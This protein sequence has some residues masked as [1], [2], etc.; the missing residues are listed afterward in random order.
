MC[1]GKVTL[2]AANTRALGR[3]PAWEQG[4]CC[5]LLTQGFTPSMEKKWVAKKKKKMRREVLP[6][7]T[8]VLWIN[9]HTPWVWRKCSQVLGS[10]SLQSWAGAGRAAASSRRG[11]G[12]QRQ[13]V[14]KAGCIF[15][16]VLTP[17]GLLPL[18]A[19]GLGCACQEQLPGLGISPE[20]RLRGPTGSWGACAG[21]E[22]RASG[23][24]TAKGTK[25]N[26]QKAA[27]Q[28]AGLHPLAPRGRTAVAQAG[29][30]TAG[31]IPEVTAAR[32]SLFTL[33][34]KSG[35][36]ESLSLQRVR[37][38]P[39]PHQ[40]GKGKKPR[41]YLAAGF[42]KHSRGEDGF[43]WA[44]RSQEQQESP[45]AGFKHLKLNQAQVV[46]GREPHPRVPREADPAGS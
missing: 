23:L 43:P 6:A 17:A 5:S 3:A 21:G 7:P 44:G 46:T 19:D 40:Q 27:H 2:R 15:G 4:L 12:N 24:L 20:S 39:P 9:P 8:A 41:V 26:Q 34:G 13:E 11:A 1:G 30:V 32:L 16:C 33:Q 10:T 42:V 22:Q 45:R 29:G 28:P 25:W 37:N 38:K 35:S 14:E 36:V 31:T 18:R